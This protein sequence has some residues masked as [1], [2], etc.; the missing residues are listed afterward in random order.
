MCRFQ[1]KFMCAALLVMRCAQGVKL[2]VGVQ[3]LVSRRC[4]TQQGCHKLYCCVGT[5]ITVRANQQPYNACLG[6]HDQVL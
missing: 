1:L 6:L 5:L 2:G 3:R 4:R